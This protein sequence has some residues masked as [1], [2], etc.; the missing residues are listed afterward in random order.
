MRTAGGSSRPLGKGPQAL[1]SFRL[2]KCRFQNKPEP[3]KASDFIAAL[4]WAV[5]S[6][7]ERK[8]KKVLGEV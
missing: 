7:E 3:S 8:F 4:S 6:P 5:E 1:E 2:Q